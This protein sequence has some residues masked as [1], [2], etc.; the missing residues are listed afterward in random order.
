MVAVQLGVQAEE[1]VDRLRAF[2]YACGRSLSEVSADI[3]ARRLTLRDQD[4]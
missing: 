1:G 2:A 4:D 3:I